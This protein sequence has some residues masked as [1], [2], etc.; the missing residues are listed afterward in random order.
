MRSSLVILLGT[1]ASSGEL[2]PMNE[3]AHPKLLTWTFLIFNKWA[4]WG[5]LN[6]PLCVEG[7]IASG[8]NTAYLL[9]NISEFQAWNLRSLDLFAVWL[10]S[11]PPWTGDKPVMGSYQAGKNWT[12]WHHGFSLIQAWTFLMLC[13][14]YRSRRM[15]LWKPATLLRPALKVRNKAQFTLLG[16]GPRYGSLLHLL[17]L[18]TFL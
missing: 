17:S 4:D 6:L 7:A 14:N 13:L 16:A 15:S 8:I 5:N 3:L 18:R 10:F 2:N 9:V 11:R 1:V 12:S